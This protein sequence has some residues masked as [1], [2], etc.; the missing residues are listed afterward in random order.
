LCRVLFDALEKG[1]KGT[2]YETFITDLYQGQLEGEDKHYG[3]TDRE[4]Y[5]RCSKCGTKSSRRDTF[6]DLSLVIK[7]FGC[8][9]SVGSVEEA[10]AKYIEA[11]ILNGD[12]KYFC[13]AC[14]SKVIITPVELTLSGRCSKRI[15]HC[16]ST[17]RP[18]PP[19]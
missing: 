6:L 10:I 14:N 13:G 3:F 19:T 8:K 7:P 11:E 18:H 12:N 5:V 4:D 2:E 17:L 9:V 1:F 15:G 16:F